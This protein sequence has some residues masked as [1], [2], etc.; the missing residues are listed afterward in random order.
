[1]VNVIITSEMRVGS[2]WLHYLLKDLLGM[3]VSPEI[4]SSEL[5]VHA[6]VVR[7]RFEEKRIVK[8]HHATQHDI[9]NGLKPHDYK[10]LAIVRNPRD[11]VTS[12]TFHQRYKPPG[13]GL[14]AIKN[15]KNDK[16]AVKIA[17]ETNMAKE[18]NKRQFI[19]MEPCKS[20][21]RYKGDPNQ[22]YLWTTYHWMKESLYNEIKTICDFLGVRIKPSAIRRICVKHSFKGRSGREPGKEVRTNEWF[23]KGTEGDFE[24]WFSGKMLKETKEID[25]IYWELVKHEESE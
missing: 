14:E 8:F 3:K 24:N 16:K 4:D 25:D 7:Q 15:A 5:S 12:W 6:E 11:R 22:K 10:V 9:L 20:T 17:L 18:A 21:K 1:M 13:K 23:R 19:L 2:R